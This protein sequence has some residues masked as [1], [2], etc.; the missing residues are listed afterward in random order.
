MI[1]R[2]VIKKYEIRKNTSTYKI[3][4]SNCNYQTYGRTTRSQ[5]LIKSSRVILKVSSHKLKL[6]LNTHL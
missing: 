6:S 4:M 1:C 5:K 3:V 2:G